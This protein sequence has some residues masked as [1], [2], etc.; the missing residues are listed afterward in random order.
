LRSARISPSSSAALSAAALLA[1][2]VA[3]LVRDV[4]SSIA[5]E[6]AALLGVPVAAFCLARALGR[7]HRLPSSGDRL[8]GRRREGHGGPLGREARELGSIILAGVDRLRAFGKRGVA[9]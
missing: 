5:A 1:V 4:A 6:F 2:A 3:S 9:A 8:C 7:L